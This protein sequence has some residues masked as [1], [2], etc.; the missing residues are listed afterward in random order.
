MALPRNDCSPQV[1]YVVHARRLDLT[2]PTAGTP[3]VATSSNVP[4]QS[5]LRSSKAP[6]NMQHDPIVVSLYPRSC[7]TPNILPALCS[8]FRSDDFPIFNSLRK[9]SP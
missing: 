2:P 6:A 8:V 7:G 9:G 1:Y 4:C 3:R 5:V